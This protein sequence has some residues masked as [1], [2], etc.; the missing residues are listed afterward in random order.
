[1]YD[2]DLLHV[3]QGIKGRWNLFICGD[4]LTGWF[5]TIKNKRRFWVKFKEKNFVGKITSYILIIF[6]T[7]L[8]YFTEWIYSD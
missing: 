5:E 6:L 2:V 7:R 1:M 8:W 4:R 3:N